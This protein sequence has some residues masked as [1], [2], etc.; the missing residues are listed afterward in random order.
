MGNKIHFESKQ[1]FFGLILKIYQD[2]FKRKIF[3]V[4]PTSKILET[5]Y[6]Y[7]NREYKQ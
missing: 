4:T 6:E 2:I 3:S 7:F 1:I 5:W